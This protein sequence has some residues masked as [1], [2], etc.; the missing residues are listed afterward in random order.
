MYV[1]V[2]LNRLRVSHEFE[3]AYYTCMHT[4][5][6]PLHASHREE[7]ERERRA[8]ALL[9]KLLVTV[10]RRRWLKL[11][12]RRKEGKEGGEEEG[13]QAKG[14]VQEADKR[15]KRKEEKERKKAKAETEKWRRRAETEFVRRKSERV[16]SK[17][18]LRPSLARSNTISS[19][20]SKNADSAEGEGEGRPFFSLSGLIRTKL[21]KRLVA[22]RQR[23]QEPASQILGQRAQEVAR[24]GEGGREEEREEKEAESVEGAGGVASGGL[25]DRLRE[26]REVM[27]RN[28]ELAASLVQV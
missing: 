12:S 19:A 11:A 14:R 24:E 1:C 9:E 15:A 13:S 25:V 10:V 2:K 23:F 6:L 8:N 4:S 22:A 3:H 5:A 26:L 21:R 20:H 18:H 27:Q 7:E 16:E 28:R 17:L